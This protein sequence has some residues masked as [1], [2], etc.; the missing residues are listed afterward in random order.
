LT[1][2]EP[3]IETTR[4][5]LPAELASWEIQKEHY[6]CR[7]FDFSSQEQAFRFVAELS[8]LIVQ[9]QHKISLRTR[10]GRVYFD[11][12]VAEDGITE[13]QLGFIQSIDALKDAAT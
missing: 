13:E 8:A 12:D 5:P 3:E 9:H 11:L 7:S 6:M 2:S 4:K 1:T 10:A